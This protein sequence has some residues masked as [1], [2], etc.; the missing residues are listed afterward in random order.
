[1]QWKDFAESL[2]MISAWIYSGRPSVIQNFDGQQIDLLKVAKE[3]LLAGTNPKSKG[4]WGYICDYDQRI[5]EAADIALSVW[6]LRGPLVAP[7][8]FA[9]KRNDFEMASIGKWE[10]NS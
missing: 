3:G 10:N 7:T 1:M 4:F 2:P 5:V 8:F 6:L 9:R